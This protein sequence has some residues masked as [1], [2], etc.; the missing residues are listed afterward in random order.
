MKNIGGFLWKVLKSPFFIMGTAFVIWMIFFDSQSYVNQQKEKAR[1][2][3]LLEQKVHDQKGVV[4][5]QQLQEDIKQDPEA[6]EKFAR[7]NYQ[8]KRKGEEIYVI[9][10]KK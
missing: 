2:Q 4:E 10:K 3:E 5:M 6:L 8:Y 9:E 7:E 1:Y